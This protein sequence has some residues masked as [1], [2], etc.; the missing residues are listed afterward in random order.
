MR[1]GEEGGGTPPQAGEGQA[2]DQARPLAGR[3]ALVTGST[4]GLG[5]AI[6]ARLAEAGCDILLHGLATEAEAAPIRAELEARHGVA[7]GYHAAQLGDAAAIAAMMQA[8]GPLDILVNNAATRH[9]GPIEEMTPADWEEDLSVN[10]SAAFHTI[11][12][13]LPG[14]KARGFGR[15]VNMSSIYGL[16]GAADRVGYVVTKTALIGLTRAVAA[17]TARFDITCNAICPGTTLTPGIEARLQSMMQSGGLDR[18]GAEAAVLQGK[19]PTG[20]FV[21]ADA[22]AALVALLASPG[23][24][25]ITGSALPV[26]GGWS[27]S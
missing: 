19:Q 23:G 5:L 25:D 16:I 2:Q 13:A 8:A 12:L 7:V 27:V 24:R 14:M 20:R 15:I 6:A 21:Q 26:D 22:V 3:R 9:F 11:R 17:E 18:P 4:G 1:L 10:L